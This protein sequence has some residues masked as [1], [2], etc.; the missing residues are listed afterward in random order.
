MLTKVVPIALVVLVLGGLIAYSKYQPIPDRVSGYVEADEIRVGSR[1]GGRVAEVLV[2]E[3]DRVEPNEVL[4][5]LEP[6]DLLERQKNA[7][8]ELAARDADF[9]RM[10]AGLRTEEVGQAKARYEQLQARLDQL[11]SGPRPQ[12]IDAARARLQVAQ[13][14]R[15]L[16]DEIF[17][18]TKTAREA[19]AASPQD[20]D[21]AVAAVAS[22]A[23]SVLA[24]QRELDL[25]VAGTREEEIR[26]ARATVDEARLAAEL[27]EKGYRQ[28]EIDAAEA[29]RDAA[30]ASLAVIA[31]QVAELEV[32]APVAGV[33]ESLEIRKGDLAAAGGPVLS[34]IDDGHMWVR[35]YVPENRLDIQVGQPVAVSVDSWPDKRFAAKIT[36]ISPQAEFTPSNTQTYDERVKQ[37]FRIKATLDEGLDKLRPGMPA[38]VWLDAG[39]GKAAKSTSE[40]SDA[41]KSSP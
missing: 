19:N 7:E 31:A 18:R 4:L 29:A 2:E 12:E 32:H 16:A 38:D 3:G 21:R 20:F 6:F 9:R 39:E 25:L 28:E 15:R 40:E 30:K 36:L 11:V 34:I 14:E 5:R 41:G 35:A 13:A 10:K 26:E 33:I 8:A 27:A 23:G 17:A 37:V 24:S 22:A 1:V